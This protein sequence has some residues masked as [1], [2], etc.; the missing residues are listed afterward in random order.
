MFN[1]SAVPGTAPSVS[2]QGNLFSKDEAAASRSDAT[3]QEMHERGR[4]E[5]AMEQAGLPCRPF[6]QW[7]TNYRRRSKAK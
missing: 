6:D 1:N 3:E 2:S 5:A 4:Y 7:L